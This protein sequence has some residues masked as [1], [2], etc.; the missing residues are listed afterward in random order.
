[1]LLSSE[2][3]LEQVD[4]AFQNNRY[5]RNTIR[6][7]EDTCRSKNNELNGIKKNFVQFPLDFTFIFIFQAG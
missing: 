7:R 2:S 4:V 1:M 5:S 6:T 3:Y